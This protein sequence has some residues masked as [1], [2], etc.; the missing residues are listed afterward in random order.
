[1]PRAAMIGA[2]L[3]GRAW[4]G[5]FARAGWD[6]TIYDAAEG[7]VERAAGLIAEGLEEQAA[8]GL[9]AEPKQAAARVRL[10]HSL[11]EALDGA[12]FVQEN[13]P[14]RVELKREIFGE[15]DRL[16]PAQIVLA[17]STSAIVASRFTESLKTRER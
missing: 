1:M 2:G 8:L 17:S 15:L 5:V 6:V 10:A 4:A 14:E 13:L 11:A 9:V 16:A 3:I 12:D 7:A